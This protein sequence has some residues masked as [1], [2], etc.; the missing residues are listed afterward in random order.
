MAVAV[1]RLTLAE[2]L[3]YDDGEDGRYELLNGELIPMSLGTGK[4]GE[5]IHSLERQFE[6]EIEN[7]GL[8]W[9]ARKGLIGVQSPRAGRWE[10]SRIPDVTVMVAEQWY[11]MANREAVILAH[12]TPP[13]LVVEVVSES[14]KTVDYRGKVS[15]YA[16]LNISEYWIVD[17]LDNRVTVC[18][19]ADGLYDQLFFQ[20]DEV[21]TSSIFPNLT[22]TAAQ[23]LVGS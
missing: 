19:L 16:V 7:A 9:I 18:T 1:Q 20:G 4:H 13:I 12:E 11:G 5:I 22:C 10:T 23:I 17:P 15:E 3:Q 6:R 8:P 14:T 21:I 2:Y